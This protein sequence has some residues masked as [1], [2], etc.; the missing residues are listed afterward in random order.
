M[1]CWRELFVEPRAGEED[2]YPVAG[3]E[4]ELVGDDADVDGARGDGAA[5]G[6]AA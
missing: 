5:Q 1:S 2:V 4:V 3:R 6:G